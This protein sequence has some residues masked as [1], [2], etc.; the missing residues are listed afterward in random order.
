MGIPFAGIFL[1]E[2]LNNKV[3]TMKDVEQL[4]ST[5]VIGE[6][7]HNDSPET[8]V[9]TTGNITPVVEMI[10]YGHSCVFQQ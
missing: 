1:K 8:L 5:P 10:I 7:M 3:Q 6:I 4:T 2:L 9:V